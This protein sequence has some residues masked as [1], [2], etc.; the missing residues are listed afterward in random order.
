MKKSIFSTLSVGASFIAFSLILSSCNSGSSSIGGSTVKKLPPPA[1]LGTNEKG[2]SIY[3]S[4]TD[5]TIAPNDKATSGVFSLS[6]GIPGNHYKLSF[7][8]VSRSNPGSKIVPTVTTI[9]S[10]CTL[11]SGIDDDHTA[12]IIDISSSKGV[13]LG[14]YDVTP[15]L[16]DL[17]TQTAYSHLDKIHV[18]VTSAAST[19]PS[20]SITLNAQNVGVAKS[21][22]GYAFINNAIGEDVY[23]IDINTDNPTIATVS[24]SNCALSVK[25]QSCKLT[26]TGVTKSQTGTYITARGRGID[27]ADSVPFSVGQDYHAYFIVLNGFVQCDVD[28]QSGVLPHTCTYIYPQTSSIGSLPPIY[29]FQYP[30]GITFKDGYIYVVD[31]ILNIYGQCHV[32]SQGIESQTCNTDSLSGENSLNNPT[33]IAVS[34]GFAYIAN[35]SN[36]TYT[37]CHINE[38]ALIESTTCSTFASSK[39]STVDYPRNIVAFNDFAYIV[40]GDKNS[41]TQCKFDKTSGITPQTC[42]TKTITSNDGL[43]HL[44][45]L[46]VTNNFAYFANNEADVTGLVYTQCAISNQEIQPETCANHKIKTNLTHA[47]GI[48]ENNGFVYFI[49]SIE[50]GYVQCKIDDNGINPNTCTLIQESQKTPSLGEF[51]DVA[52]D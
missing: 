29:T 12:C 8:V 41:F 43:L 3:A 50:N 27:T 21:I 20:V 52:F 30:Q 11:T 17:T 42:T 48:A 9:P 22:T 1:K 46:A 4:A 2:S 33:A 38:S 34:N 31:F 51:Y 23:N 32:N 37:Q 36:N 49:S 26:I 16:N 19:N 14:T 25:N 35:Y 5:F 10:D 40:Y 39:L 13:A 44:T 24:P 18:T 15:I 47:L 28:P 7:D 45:S 6:G